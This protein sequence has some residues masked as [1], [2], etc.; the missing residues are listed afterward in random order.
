MKTFACRA[1]GRSS[2]ADTSQ[3]R[4]HRRSPRR[5]WGRA[6]LRICRVLP[7]AP[8]TWHVHAARRADPTSLPARAKRDSAVIPE[9]RRVFEENFGVEGTC[10]RHR[11]GSASIKM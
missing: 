8:S 11:F 5:V 9:V 7:I 2:T 1:M 3:D 4:L 6:D 10:I